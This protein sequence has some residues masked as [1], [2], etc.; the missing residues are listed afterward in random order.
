MQAVET[1]YVQPDDPAW[2]KEAFALEGLREIVGGAHERKI[3][4]FFAEAGHGWVKDDETAWCA[5]F[6]HAMLGRAGLKGTGSLAARSYLGWGAKTA[7]PQRGDVA[8][9]KRG[10]SAWQGHVAFFLGEGGAHV[11]VIGGNQS[12]AVTV[13][14]YPRS[15]LLGYRRP[16]GRSKPPPPPAD[17]D[18]TKSEDDLPSAQRTDPAASAVRYVQTRLRELGYAEVGKAD[19]VVGPMT[20]AAILAFRADNGLE[21]TPAIDDALLVALPNA[22]PRTLA[23]ER[24]GATAKEVRDQVPEVRA[25][26]FGKA[27]SGIAAAVGGAGAGLSWLWE[28]LGDVRGQVQPVLD[29]LGDVPAWLYFA[30]FAGAA[31]FAWH[32]MRQGEAAGV[33]AFQRGERR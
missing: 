2:L 32:R 24:A 5:A 31:L 9:F 4:D 16:P 6:V 29:T 8:V 11:W 1:V 13:A 23:P 19:G 28:N 27:W 22:A 17:W 10:R 18:N 20:R 30:L 3:L 21:L 25:S 14:R 26:F 15:S 7:K 33:A 12:N